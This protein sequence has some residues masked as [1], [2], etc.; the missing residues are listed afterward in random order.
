[1]MN[2]PCQLS[3]GNRK[4]AAFKVFHS[5]FSY[6]NMLN[7]KEFAA[8]T[9]LLHMDERYI[10][11]VC[12]ELWPMPALMTE[13]GMFLK[14]AALAHECRA[15]YMV[16]FTSKPAS[17]AMVL[18]LL[19]WYESAFLYWR[20]I[21]L[22]GCLII[23]NKNGLSPDMAWRL[24]MSCIHCSQRTFIS[25]F[26]LRRRYVRIPPCKSLFCKYAISTKDMPRV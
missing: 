14:Y 23:G 25:W 8:S 10:S 18:S 17:M 19:L 1:M 16:R 7:I 4:Q 2:V 24:T 3:D 20:R 6:P 9:S 26:V 11:V 13:T 12:S 15:T 21:G 5:L 22:L